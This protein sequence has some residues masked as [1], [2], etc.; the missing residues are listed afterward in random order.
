[1]NDHKCF[2]C[3]GAATISVILINSLS[4]EFDV[5]EP[6]MNEIWKKYGSHPNVHFCFKKIEKKEVCR[7]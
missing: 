2:Q 6:C 4:H 7:D 5:C 3:Q 1:M